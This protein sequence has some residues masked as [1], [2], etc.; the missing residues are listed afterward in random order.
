MHNFD[1]KLNKLT[2]NENCLSQVDIMVEL[3]NIVLR[4]SFNM[5][6]EF[7]LEDS[8]QIEMS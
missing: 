3:G 7:S 2:D 1:R 5:Q 4:R 8:N 6:E